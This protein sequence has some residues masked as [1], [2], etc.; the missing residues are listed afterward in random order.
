VTAGETGDTG[1]RVARVRKLTT[2]LDSSLRIPFTRRTIG[3]D[4]IL[5]LVPW[6]GDAIG[7]VLSGYL[8]WESARLGVSR[9]TLVRMLLNVALETVVGVIPLIGDL[10]DATWKANSR[11]LKM[12]DRHLADPDAVRLASRR[13][14]LGVGMGVV[15][16]VGGTVVVA[17]WL[18]MGILRA[19]GALLGVG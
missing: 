17:G 18:T 16:A 11:N 1:R 12:L 4:P 8:V 10:F 13:F 5:G 9:G 15:G 7:A 14:W 3:L 2:V 6:A 19:L